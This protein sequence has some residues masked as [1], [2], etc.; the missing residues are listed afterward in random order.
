MSPEKALS[1]LRE[2]ASAPSP[3]LMTGASCWVA[4]EGLVGLQNQAIGLAE[5]LGLSY[6][7]KTVGK[8]KSLWKLLPPSYWPAPLTLTE[9]ARA[10]QAPWP[11]VLITAGRCGVAASLAV[12]KASEG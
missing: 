2:T 1:A 3:A 4:S 5:A 10:L 11:D 6:A 8:P 7:V 12:R 9:S